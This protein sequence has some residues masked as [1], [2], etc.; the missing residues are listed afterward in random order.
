MSFTK[1]LKLIKAEIDQAFTISTPGLR[2]RAKLLRSS[3]LP[4]CPLRELA[5][6][7]N[8]IEDDP[9]YLTDEGKLI[10]DDYADLRGL[11]Y[12]GIGS[13]VHTIL[14]NFLP[15]TYRKIGVLA[16][17]DVEAV[18]GCEIADCPNKNGRIQ[19]VNRKGCRKC[20]RHL[21][22]VEIE[23]YGKFTSHTDKIYV[24]G[25]RVPNSTKIRWTNRVIILDIKTC[26]SKQLWW[27]RKK[28]ST[29]PVKKHVHQI[30]SYCVTLTPLL[31]K[32]GYRVTGSAILYIP[33]DKI[34]DFELIPARE[35]S[36]AAYTEIKAR[37]HRVSDGWR[38]I[39]RHLKAQTIASQAA[40][41]ECHKHKLCSSLQW[42]QE[43]VEDTFDKCQ[44]ASVCFNK[45]KLVKR[46][47]Q[48]Q[49]NW[50]KHNGSAAK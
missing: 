18:G 16:R 14:Q 19:V 17:W 21:P 8:P 28:K 40:A 35:W 33:R 20:G 9:Y 32:M 42:Y 44:L 49:A 7:L 30:D 3:S 29:L 22:H 26:S 2:E 48:L 39:G 37:L 45:Q 15:Q 12:T 27:W 47:K 38:A 1:D 43:N 41:Q 46:L 50:D 5:N 34:D 6:T 13:V 10:K 11:F 31:T 23:S 36:Q 4:Y 24:I 25:E